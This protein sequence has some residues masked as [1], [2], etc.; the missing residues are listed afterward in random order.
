MSE[1]GRL[2]PRRGPARI[3]AGVPYA[4][5]QTTLSLLPGAAIGEWLHEHRH[6]VTGRLLDAGC[7]NRPYAEW[8]GP[9]VNESVGLDLAP[10]PGVTVGSVE[11]MPFADAEFDAVLCTEVLEHVGDA[12]RA[13]AELFRVTR[14]GG[15][16]LV[17]VPFLYPT[18]E[19]PYDMRRLTHLGL[20]DLMQR[21]GFQVIGVEAAGGPVRLA[22]HYLVLA[23][24]AAAGRHT[25]RSLVRTALAAPQQAL[26]RTRPTPRGLSAAARRASLGY[27]AAARRP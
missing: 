11:Q 22:L 15:H 21:H 19:A 14:P 20:H 13:T 1:S 18:H 23:A 12:E 7:G 17:T 8:Y 27:M 5:P 4:D 25:E 10:L 16:V 26:V 2:R 24:V 6:L 3:V 9:L